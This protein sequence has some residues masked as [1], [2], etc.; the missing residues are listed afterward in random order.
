[1]S[2]RLRS[3]PGIGSLAGILGAAAIR[4]RILIKQCWC[5]EMQNARPNARNLDKVLNFRIIDM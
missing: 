5:S 1:V 3:S 2:K 4:D